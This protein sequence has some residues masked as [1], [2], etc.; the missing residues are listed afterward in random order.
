MEATQD[1]KLR[2]VL[3][4]LSE[5]V[6]TIAFKVGPLLLPCVFSHC[7][8]QDMHTSR[9]AWHLPLT[10]HLLSLWSTSSTLVLAQGWDTGC[11]QPEAGRLREAA[12][13]CQPRFCDSTC[14]G[15]TMQV[16]A[17]AGADGVVQR[18]QLREHL[19]R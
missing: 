2:Q 8:M 19:R 10:R 3:M 17:C 12:C 7:S 6:R 15:E 16:R 9:R 13:M 1:A 14:A 5:A 11:D 4:S 18:G